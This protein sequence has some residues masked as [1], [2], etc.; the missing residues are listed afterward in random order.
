MTQ[1][2]WANPFYP[3]FINSNDQKT[4][5]Y[6]QNPPFEDPIQRNK[7]LDNYQ[8]NLEKLDQFLQTEKLNHVESIYKSFN[9]NKK[10]N[11]YMY[12]FE[13]GTTWDILPYPLVKKVD[14]IKP[15]NWITHF[16]NKTDELNIFQQTSFNE[17]INQITES[18]A[19]SNN[20]LELLKTPD[21]YQKILQK[22]Q[23]A[24][25][26]VFMSTFLFQCDAGSEQLLNILEEKIRTG[27]RFFLILDSTFTLADRKCL[28]K[29]KKI[30]V[31]LALQGSPNKIFHEKMYVFDGEYGIID[32]QNIVAAQT[33]SNGHNNLINDTGVGIKGPMVGQIAQRFI[34]HWENLLKKNLPDDLK[35]FYDNLLIKDDKYSTIPFVTD[36]LIKKQGVCRLV[37]N[38]PGIKNPIL[39]M[40][41]A[42]I[43]SAKKYLF[44]NMIDL[45][46]ERNFGNLIGK[47]FL[48]FVSNKAN[49]TPQMRIDMLTNHWKL[50]T[51]I[52]LPKGLAA[53]PTLFSHVITKPGKLIIDLPYKQITKG[54]IYLEKLVKHQNFHWWASALYEHSKSIMID[55]IITIIGSYNINNASENL[56]YEQTIVCH[57]EE[58]A[59]QMQKSILQNQLN[60]IP[61]F[62]K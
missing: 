42:Y 30:G 62:L 20:E 11:L 57:D 48:N 19:F 5:F 26:H 23:T 47:E 13:T 43:E 3:Y 52:A 44:F 41:K 49:S 53:K 16:E 25:N 59:K 27:L 29:L 7:D 38:T 10:L 12:E 8:L 60:S 33:L 24:K 22:I 31:T 6:R 55:N 46:F 54:K 56:S 9:L 4:T 15:E 61:I 37:T 35:Q 45:R 2:L 39:L 21:S 36:G 50:P 40:Y 28:K 1:N 17:K 51:D 58:L 34:Y 32:G 18:K 14:S